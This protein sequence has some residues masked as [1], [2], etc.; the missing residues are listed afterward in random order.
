M[1]LHF[2]KEDEAK[3]VYT[4]FKNSNSN[5]SNV[6]LRIHQKEAEGEEES[7]EQ[8]GGWKK[9]KRAEVDDEGF[10]MIN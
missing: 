8:E 1:N 2:F 9:K 4:Y 10:S 5:F 3:D 6:E 7:K